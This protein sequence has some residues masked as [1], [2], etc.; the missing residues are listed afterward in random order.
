M[1]RATGCEI[2]GIEGGKAVIEAERPWKGEGRW[3]E[4]EDERT[5][6]KRMEGQ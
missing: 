6:R 3:A 1:K 4:L 5:L 2:E